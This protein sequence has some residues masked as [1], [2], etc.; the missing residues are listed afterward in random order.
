MSLLDD[1]QN[2]PELKLKKS[3][4]CMT[5]ALIRDLPIAESTQLQKLLGDAS[6]SKS[7]LAR[8]LVANGYRI[9]AATMTRH[10]RGECVAGR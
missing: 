4:E 9:T 10:I 1:L 8:I 2:S 7:A 5:C 6:V 3:L